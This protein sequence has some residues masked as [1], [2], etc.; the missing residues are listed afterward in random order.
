MGRDTVALDYLLEV[1]IQALFLKNLTISL[2]I[3]THLSELHNA[4]FLTNRGIFLKKETFYSVTAI[5]VVYIG[6]YDNLY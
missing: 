5:R 6:N 1:C 3:M 2:R 4:L